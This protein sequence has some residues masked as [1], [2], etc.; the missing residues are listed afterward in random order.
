M[1]RRLLNILCLVLCL[2]LLAG[3]GEAPILKNAKVNIRKVIN[4]ELSALDATQ[5][6]DMINYM[7]AGSAGRHVIYHVP[8]LSSVKG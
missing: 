7:S 3:C 8:A 2:I 5:S 1:K 4:I 6:R